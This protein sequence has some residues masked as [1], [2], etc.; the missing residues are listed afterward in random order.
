MNTLK[1]QSSQLMKRMQIH[2]Y[3]ER[4]KCYCMDMAETYYKCMKI[5][6][7]GEIFINKSEL[8]LKDTKKITCSVP[9]K[10]A[11]IKI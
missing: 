1:L 6:K 10:I 8:N 3:M 4:Q 9:M 11:N 5:L 7:M 2:S